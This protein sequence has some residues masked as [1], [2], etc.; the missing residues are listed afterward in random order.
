MTAVKKLR[1]INARRRKSMIRMMW[2]IA[3]FALLG[4]IGGWVF[5]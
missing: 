1:K 5:G 2:F 4:A 3:V